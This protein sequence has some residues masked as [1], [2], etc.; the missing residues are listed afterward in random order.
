MFNMLLEVA[1]EIRMRVTRWHLERLLAM[2]RFLLD[3]VPWRFEVARRPS[4]GEVHCYKIT[5]ILYYL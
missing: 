1:S 4:S 3:P 2:R 5:C